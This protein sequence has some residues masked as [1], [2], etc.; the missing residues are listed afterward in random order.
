[1]DAI[2]A[3]LDAFHL[4]A[5]VFE[6][7][8]FCGRWALTHAGGEQASF[9]LVTDGRCWLDRGDGGEPLALDAGDLLVMPRD[10]PHRLGPA[11][12]IGPAREPE[13]RPL[14]AGGDGPGLMCG[15]FGF[16][17]GVRN[18]ILDALPDYLL[19]RADEGA[20]N[21]ALHALV[22]LIMAEAGRD[23]AGTDAMINRLS[24][25]LF[26]EVVRHYAAR[27]EAPGGLLAGLADPVVGRALQ[28]LHARPAQPWTLERLAGEAAAS[29]TVLTARFRATLGV[30]P[31]TYLF[32]WRM[33]LARRWLREGG[34]VARVA[35]DCGYATEAGFSKAFS[36]HFGVG[37]GAVRRGRAT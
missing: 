34:T 6:R 2:S 18:P 28:A 5:S 9:H 14:A 30:A 7:A 4:N 10:A 8:R 33:Q 37:P 13:R 3:I 20:G 27:A 26:I 36:R 16:D 31:M 12:E 23:A 11:R 21:R 1:M 19:I 29:R 35:E 15:Y 25:A 24:D 32:R 22:G 17:E